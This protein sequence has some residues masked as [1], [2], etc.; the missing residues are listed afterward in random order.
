MNKV[1]WGGGMSTSEAVPLFKFT[2]NKRSDNMS[3]LNV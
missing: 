1:G 3:E 2:D